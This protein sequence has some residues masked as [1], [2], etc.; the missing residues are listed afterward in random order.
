MTFVCKKSDVCHGVIE[1]HRQL[2]KIMKYVLLLAYCVCIYR[3]S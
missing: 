3:E 1:T 2:V